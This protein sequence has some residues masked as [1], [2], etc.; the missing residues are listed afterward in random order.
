MNLFHSGHGGGGEGEGLTC[1]QVL[2]G[3]SEISMVVESTM[4]TSPLLMNW[5]SITW[6]IVPL[7]PL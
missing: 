1:V 5:L 4:A 2:T 7:K 6:S 3:N